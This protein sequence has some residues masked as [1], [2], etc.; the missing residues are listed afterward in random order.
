MPKGTPQA[1]EPPDDEGVSFSEVGEHVIQNGS[2]GL[3]PTGR[4]PLDRA[5]AGRLQP[6]QLQ[7]K[8]LV[9]GRDPGRATIHEPIVSRLDEQRL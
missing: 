6:V 8:G 1:I 4:L 5:A 3:G 2:I 7:I 9:P